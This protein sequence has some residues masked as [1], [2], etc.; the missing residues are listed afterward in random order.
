LEEIRDRYERPRSPFVISGCVGPQGDGY[1]PEEVL[2]ADA[3][4]SA[5]AW[6]LSGGVSP[7]R[8]VSRDQFRVMV[9]RVG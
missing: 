7:G 2:S 1:A 4:E 6:T 8:F 9:A 3:A 5:P